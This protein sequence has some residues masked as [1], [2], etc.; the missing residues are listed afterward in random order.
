MTMSKPPA[1]RSIPASALWLS[2]RAYLAVAV[3]EAQAGG[4]LSDE[5]RIRLAR[6]GYIGDGP[7]WAPRRTDSAL[8]L[9]AE[10]MY[11]LARRI[12]ARLQ[13]SGIPSPPG[14]DTR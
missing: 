7:R 8:E 5:D 4:A 6:L 12:G 11:L 1:V 3:T 9:E 10:M 2:A 13:Q 14:G